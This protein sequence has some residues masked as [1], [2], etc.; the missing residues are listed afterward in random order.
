MLVGALVLSAAVAAPRT[1]RAQ[2]TASAADVKAQFV[3]RFTR[4]IDWPS[5]VLASKRFTLCVA[6]DGP[7]TRALKAFAARHEIKQRAARVREVT[8]DDDLG[9]CWA[10]FISDSERGE[11]PAL[12][13]KV[14]GKP[15]LTIGDS[16]A[17]ADD[18]VMMSFYRSGR[19]V[20]FAIDPDRVTASGLK[21]R[22]KLLRL[23]R[24]ARR[25][26]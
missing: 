22:S 20:R 10:L 24:Q 8:V 21:A 2:P 17:F 19:R 11:A 4:F 3:E 18:G 13:T 14:E 12:L 23:G 16:T 26:R 7:T 25:E 15:V 9:D 6:G 5:A 1:T